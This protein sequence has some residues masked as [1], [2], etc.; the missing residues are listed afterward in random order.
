MLSNKCLVVESYQPIRTEKYKQKN[1][2]PI[3]NFSVVGLKIYAA[4]VIRTNCLYSHSNYL[5]SSLLVFSLCLSLTKI[6][7]LIYY[8]LCVCMNPSRSA[9]QQF[10]FLAHFSFNTFSLFIGH[11]EKEKRVGKSIQGGKICPTI[12]PI[13]T[14]K[15]IRFLSYIKCHEL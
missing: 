11:R 6:T 13:Q 8:C 14:S 1:Y 15:D 7:G 9:A 12:L 4:I 5:D 10:P 2:L 3:L